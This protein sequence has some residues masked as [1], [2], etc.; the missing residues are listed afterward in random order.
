MDD[1]RGGRRIPEDEDPNTVEMGERRR[2]QGMAITWDQ[3]THMAIPT[4][5]LGR[6]CLGLCDCAN[7]CSC[8]RVSAVICGPFAIGGLQ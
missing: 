8:V 2:D 5:G 6:C 3:A 1:L 7:P 4:R